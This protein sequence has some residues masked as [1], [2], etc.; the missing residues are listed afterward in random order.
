MDGRS[1]FC[2]GELADNPSN[3]GVTVPSRVLKVNMTYF[4]LWL[5]SRYNT[6]MYISVALIYQNNQSKNAGGKT[7]ED[8]VGIVRINQVRY[9]WDYVYMLFYVHY[10]T[11]LRQMYGYHIGMYITKGSNGESTPRQHLQRL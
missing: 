9:I 5:M 8:Y 4:L 7:C 6:S 11:Y 1:S 2:Q 3:D 10:M